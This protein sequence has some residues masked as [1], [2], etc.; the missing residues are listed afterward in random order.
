MWQRILCEQERASSVQIDKQ[1]P[2]IQRLF[3]ERLVDCKCRVVDEDVYMTEL[4]DS[5][6]DKSSWAFDRR[7]IGFHRDGF[8]R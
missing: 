6:L 2:I 1:I 7:N 4:S 3:F 8:G 5:F